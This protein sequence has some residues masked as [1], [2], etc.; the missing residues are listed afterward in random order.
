M[1]DELFKELKNRLDYIA[2][3]LLKSV[4][5]EIPG[6]DNYPRFLSITLITTRLPD[7]PIQISLDFESKTPEEIQEDVQQCSECLAMVSRESGLPSSRSLNERK[8]LF[9]DDEKYYPSGG[10][11]DAL[12]S[13]SVGVYGGILPQDCDYLARLV[14][15]SF[16]TAERFIMKG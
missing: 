11:S 2:T 10:F 14:F 13:L 6:I 15:I 1:S 16:L 4:I 7:T 3:V 12:K 9:P 8:D 5:E